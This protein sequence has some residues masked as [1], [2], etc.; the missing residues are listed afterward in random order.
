MLLSNWR[1]SKTP[2]ATTDHGI[3]PMYCSVFVTTA[4]A[5]S[6]KFKVI[7]RSLF[8]NGTIPE[9]NIVSENRPGPKRKRSYSVRIHFQVRKC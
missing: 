3:D 7:I 8:K 2:T 1:K 4:R 5:G 9:T 6:I